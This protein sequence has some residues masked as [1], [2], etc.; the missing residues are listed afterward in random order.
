MMWKIIE[1]NTR[2]KEIFKLKMWRKKMRRRIR[3]KMRRRRR[4]E[5]KKGKEMKRKKRKRKLKKLKKV[6]IN[7]QKVKRNERDNYEELY[8]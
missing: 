7:R 4:K 3:R 6:G 8:I 5:K 1:K 2:D